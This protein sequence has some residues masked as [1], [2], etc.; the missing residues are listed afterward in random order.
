MKHNEVASNSP[1]KA[2]LKYISF[3]PKRFRVNL[4]FLSLLNLVLAIL[5]LIG[6]LCLG[7]ATLRGLNDSSKSDTL[8]SNWLMSYL[9]IFNDFSTL[10]LFLIAVFVFLLRNVLTLWLTKVLLSQVSR[11]QKQ[12]SFNLFKR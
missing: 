4:L 9:K 10:G 2:C 12:L 11:H 6:L 3:L 5:D 8:N 1:I 7:L